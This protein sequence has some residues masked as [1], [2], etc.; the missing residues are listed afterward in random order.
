MVTRT[1]Y[2]NITVTG[3]LIATAGVYLLTLFTATVG[4]YQLVE[5]VAVAG[6][7]VGMTFSSTFLAIQNSASRAQIGIASSLPQFMGN[8][9]GTIGLAIMGTIQANTF[10]SKLTTVLA[11]V[12]AQY[13]ATAT[14]YLGN[15][16]LVGQF[17]ASPAALQQFLA[18][19]PAFT[20]LIPQLRLAFVQ[21][22]TPLF[23]IGLGIA[24]ASVGAAFLFKGSMKQQLLARRTAMDAAKKEAEDLPAAAPI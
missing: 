13:Q 18:E 14:Q 2:R 7:G 12:P 8:L 10:A 6:F 4:W 3:L 9:G 16:N 19:Y 24:V 11:T 15:A 1:S 23:T 5:A 21:S 17:L 22:I 20:S